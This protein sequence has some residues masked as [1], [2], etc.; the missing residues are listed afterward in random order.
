MK[1]IRISDEAYA[2]FRDRATAERRTITATIDLFVNILKGA[3][4]EGVE[5]ESIPTGKEN[6]ELEG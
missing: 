4:N 6:N 2:F 5:S 1:S 3:E